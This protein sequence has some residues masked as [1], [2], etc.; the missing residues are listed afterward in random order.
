[1]STKKKVVCFVPLLMILFMLIPMVGHCASLEFSVNYSRPSTS[2]YSGYVNVVSINSDGEYL[3]NTYCWVIY[4]KTVTVSS[5]TEHYEKKGWL[6]ISVASDGLTFSPLTNSGIPGTD[7]YTY[8]ITRWSAKGSYSKVYLGSDEKA[9]SFDNSSIVGWGFYGSG[10]SLSSSTDKTSGKIFTV[11]YSED[12]SS[13]YLKELCDLVYTSNQVSEDIKITLTSILSS[14]DDVEEQLTSVIKYLTSIKSL[15]GDVNSELELIY[16]SLGDIYN[17]QKESNH[18]LSKIYDYLED[19]E[20]REEENATINGE[21]S[22]D[23][24]QSELDSAISSS[25]EGIVSSFQNLSLAL[26]YTGTEAGWTF[27]AIKLP[28]I[29]GVMEEV[30]LTSEQTI[31]FGYWVNQIP[32]SILSVIKACTTIA[33]ILFCC[34]EIYGMISYVLVLKEE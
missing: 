33:L 25:S 15:L 23:S 13:V 6:S 5:T 16:N 4:P 26:S 3:L 24:S 19:T 11:Y 27:P 31:D 20:R 8:L 18:W 7:T 2:D 22:I 32:D 14:V 12:V 17:Q 29:S 34:K 10:Y 1:M 28:A 21:N 30:Q 9:V